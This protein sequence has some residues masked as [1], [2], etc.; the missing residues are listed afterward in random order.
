MDTIEVSGTIEGST[1]KAL[2]ID[3]GFGPQWV[4]KSLIQDGDSLCEFSS[5]TTFEIAEWFCEEEGIV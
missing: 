1:D 2:L 4:P 5:D 3:F